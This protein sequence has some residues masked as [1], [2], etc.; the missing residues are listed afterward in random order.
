LEFDNGIRLFF[1]SRPIGNRKRV[2]L[3]DIQEPSEPIEPRDLSIRSLCAISGRRFADRVTVYS[4]DAL[5]LFC[6]TGAYLLQAEVPNE[7]RRQLVFH[8]C[9]SRLLDEY[10]REYP[11]PQAPPISC[12]YQD[13][14][15]YAIRL[16]CNGEYLHIIAAN[17][18][19]MEIALS[20][21]PHTPLECCDSFGNFGR[22]VDF[23]E[24]DTEQ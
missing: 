11:I 15:L 23:K 7:R 2:G 8:P 19:E 6:D 4:E 20:T 17:Y 24:R 22:H 3:F 14:D 18:P 5:A 21:D 12:L 16:D 10:T 9:P 13:N 1:A